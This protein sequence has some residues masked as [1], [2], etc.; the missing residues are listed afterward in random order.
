[1]RPAAVGLTFALLILGSAHA[2]ELTY[3]DRLLDS[4]VKRVPDMLDSF[5]PKTGRF[6]TGI[7]ICHDQHLMYPLTVA[8]ATKSTRNPYYHDPKLLSVIVKAGDP[9]LANMDRQGQWTFTNK[10]GSTWGQIRMPWTYSRW[11]RTFRLIRDRMP[12][13]ARKAWTEALTLGYTGISKYNMRSVHNIPAHHAM[14]LYIAG[15]T[16]DRP[17]WRRQAGDFLMKIVAAQSEGGYWSEGKGPVVRYGFVYVDALGTYYAASGD[18]RVLPALERAAAFHR[19]FTY[20]GGQC[21]ETIDQ[22]NPYYDTIAP[23]NVGFTFTPT[24]R[25][26]LK[27][28]WSRLDIEHFSTDLIASLLLHG[29]EGPVEEMPP[30]APADTFLLTEG[31]AARA[32]I[33]RRGPWFVCLSAYVTPISASRWIQDRQNF[34]SVYHDQAGLILGGG[35]TKLQPAWSNFTVGDMA[36][37]AHRPG[38]TN[39]DFL[40]KGRLDHVPRAAKLVVDPEPGLGLSYGEETCRIQIEP[41]DD[42]T[43]DYRIEA[44]AVSGLPVVAHLTLIPRFGKTLLTAGGEKVTIGEKPVLLSPEQLGGRLTHAG[45]RVHLPS[46]ASLHWPAL[47]HNPYRK[48]GSATAKQGRIEIRIPLDRDHRRHKI[49]FEILP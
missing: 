20:P 23:G 36:L 45:Y 4:L 18:R 30:D 11:I 39:P 9:L 25:A 28:Q 37:L 5:D 31:G 27:H 6:G 21:V 13:E 22:R 32:A 12:P 33:V 41:R 43:L 7:W 35:N 26:Y 38:D 14:G 49:T 47:P 2:A 46:T 16:L 19:H 48:D 44:T 34:V 40:P 29:R 15:A 8:Y 1:M 17:E 10:D 42:R 3:K 24:G